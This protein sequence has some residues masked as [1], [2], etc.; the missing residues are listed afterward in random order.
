MRLFLLFVCSFVGT[1]LS[2]QPIAQQVKDVCPGA[3]GIYGNRYYTHDGRIYYSGGDSTNG[4]EL[5]I[6]DGSDAGTY[7]LKD[8]NPNAPLNYTLGNSDP[9][10][11][12]SINGKMIFAAKAA[13]GIHH[14]FWVTDGTETG[15]QP[16]ATIPAAWSK[17]MPY[18]DR[19][20]F[21]RHIAAAP[22]A[23]WIEIYVTDATPGGTQ[24]FHTT[25]ISP[26][27]SGISC[28]FLYNGKLYMGITDRAKF[29]VT[30]G[31][32]S[33]TSEVVL[34]CDYIMGGVLFNNKIYYIGRNIN[35][36]HCLYQ[37]DGTTT[38]TR[39]IKD[40]DSDRPFL[41]MHVIDGRMIIR[42]DKMWSSD[43]TTSGTYEVTKAGV[44]N[45]YYPPE[46]LNGKL[47]FTKQYG[48]YRYLTVTDGTDQGTYIVDST[49]NIVRTLGMEILKAYN[50]Y[51]FFEAQPFYDLN[52]MKFLATKS[53]LCYTSTQPNSAQALGNLSIAASSL[54]SAVLNGE[55]YISADDSISGRELW[56]I[57]ASPATSLGATSKGYDFTLYPNPAQ[58]HINLQLPDDAAVR[59]RII[60]L[61]GQTVLQG[62]ATS[63]RPINIAAIPPG[64]YF[65]VLQQSGAT[66]SK[67]FI[68]Q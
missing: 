19:A 21:F 27:L 41:G 67:T 65:I 44:Q 55:L 52:G 30:D 62:T 39:L 59:Y 28:H 63:Q 15:T 26:S 32:T 40:L 58:T 68:K 9:K 66:H 60:N 13:D 5:W 34:P 1:T 37:S 33:G 23:S 49:C 64:S 54:S 2:A 47:Y 24:L 22:P 8:I 18:K 45:Y 46:V 57:K 61:F 7:L 53:R 29:I 51:L 6:S 38:G 43:G 50:G 31:T 12:C 48:Q 35:D 17:F 14:N 10:D 42:C 3:C 4:N 16:F 56:K 11:F 25:N 36:T 20:Y